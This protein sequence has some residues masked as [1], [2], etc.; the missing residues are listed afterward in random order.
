MK[1]ARVKNETSAIPA[2]NVHPS[3]A[4]PATLPPPRSRSAESRDDEPD[5]DARRDRSEQPEIQRQLRPDERNAARRD[6]APSHRAIE[7]ERHQQR[8]Q[9]ERCGELER[10]LLRDQCTAED[11]DPG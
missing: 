8:D 1:M 6:R 9:A 5:R 2:I 10:P 4:S 11:A 3:Q 7:E